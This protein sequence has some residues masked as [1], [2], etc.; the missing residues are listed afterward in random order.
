MSTR[1]ACLAALCA[2]LA[3]CDEGRDPDPVPTPAPVEPEAVLPP[4]PSYAIHEW[5]LID[6]D[7]GAHEAELAAGPG[8]APRRPAVAEP[9][10]SSETAT[11]AATG[12]R[13]GASTSTP[14]TPTVPNLPGLPP[15]RRDLVERGVET[16]TGVFDA[17]TGG[18]AP[19]RKPVLYFHLDP[20]ATSLRVELT[21]SLGA[22]GRVI[23]H[24]P[25]AT[26]AAHQVT[27]S[28]VELAHETCSGGP[29]P[30]AD[31]PACQ[32]VPDGYCELAE[33]ARYAS[34]DASCLTFGGTQHNF[35]FY[36]GGGPA[37]DLPLTITRAPD[38]S[39]TVANTTMGTPFGPM[40][41]LRRVQGVVQVSTVAIPAPGLAVTIPP[42][43]NA[44]TEAHRAEVRQ[45]LRAIGLTEGEAEAFERAWFAE[46]FDAASSTPQAFPDAIF[47]F[48]PAEQ[49]DGYAHLEP[50]PPPS[51]TAR[52][53]AVRAGWTSL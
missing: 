1:A 30:A 6:V 43:A 46:L 16:A 19:R 3:G 15:N 11:T 7:L 38:G 37:P 34:E 42:P 4:A 44:A 21:V 5:G 39:V 36:R 24:F 2:W 26:L 23:E 28:G 18:D 52:A 49:V 27:W 50:S 8:R 14:A 29:Y 41:R 22:T 45:Q 53:M 25:P 35:L 47:F 10:P 12:R 9:T 33:L 32:S 48:L 51:A 13:S 20:P 31:A 17:L 40:L